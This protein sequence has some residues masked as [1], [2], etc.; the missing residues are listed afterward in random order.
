MRNQQETTMVEDE[1]A[2]GNR[3]GVMQQLLVREATAER[4]EALDEV[5]R[6]IHEEEVDVHGTMIKQQAKT[7]IKLELAAP[8][9]LE[10]E[11]Q[12]HEAAEVGLGVDHGVETEAMATSQEAEEEDEAE[13]H[14]ETTRKHTKLSINQT[15][16]IAMVMSA[17]SKKP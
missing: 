3:V 11:V 16:R 12:E 10:L 13:V 4:T 7:P 17:A 6:T 5:A 9:V 15:Q 1:V 2:E 14:A 8:E